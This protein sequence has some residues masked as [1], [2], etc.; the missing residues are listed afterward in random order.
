MSLSRV[1][2]LDQLRAEFASLR[3]EF[4]REKESM[5]SA[6]DNRRDWK[7]SRDCKIRYASATKFMHIAEYE[8][9]TAC[10]YAN[11]KNKNIEDVEYAINWFRDNWYKAR[12]AAFWA[13]L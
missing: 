4:I 1:E 2:Q 11:P 8:V 12:E 6:V 3:D 13:V 9:N 7:K 5:V 10:S